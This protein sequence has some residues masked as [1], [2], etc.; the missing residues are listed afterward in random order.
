MEIL[1][2]VADTVWTEMQEQSPNMD[3]PAVIRFLSVLDNFRKDVEVMPLAHHLQTALDV[4]SVVDFESLEFAIEPYLVQTSVTVDPSRAL[5]FLEDV[6]LSSMLVS[7]VLLCKIAMFA[8]LISNQGLMDHVG[9]AIELRRQSETS[10]GMPFLLLAELVCSIDSNTPR[11][12][13][14]LS[15]MRNILAQV[16]QSRK[17][18]DELFYLVSVLYR[19]ESTEVDLP[20]SLGHDLVIWIQECIATKLSDLIARKVDLYL[21]STLSNLLV[22]LDSFDNETRHVEFQWVSKF[23]DE[24]LESLVQ[25]CEN[26]TKLMLMSAKYINASLPLLE[27][28][29]SKPEF[30]LTFWSGAGLI[31]LETSVMLKIKEC[32]EGLYKQLISQQKPF[33]KRMEELE[34]LASPSVSGILTNQFYKIRSK[35]VHGESGLTMFDLKQITQFVRTFL[36]KV[37]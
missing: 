18:E 7:P 22:A 8:R 13:S 9:K 26:N 25:L 5:E 6:D 15:D 12:T 17:M 20:D 11:R 31:L 2:L 27:M 23:R 19:A 30:A 33:K 21:D 16:I 3:T 10:A 37:L 36:K 34:K 35:V 1:K 24:D 32:D 29:E 4:S 14:L 28:I